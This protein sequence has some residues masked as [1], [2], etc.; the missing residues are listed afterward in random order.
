MIGYLMSGIALSQFCHE[1]AIEHGL[2]HLHLLVLINVA[3]TAVI[4]A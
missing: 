1:V 3:F 4:A 2:S